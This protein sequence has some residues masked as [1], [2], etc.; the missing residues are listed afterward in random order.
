MVISE[1]AYAFWLKPAFYGR[2]CY[3][4]LAEIEL[5]NIACRACSVVSF[6][7]TKCELEA[8]ESFHTFECK[9]M[10]V[11]Q[12]L[13]SGH[14]ALRMI[15]QVGIER[16]LELYEQNKNRTFNFQDEYSGDYDDVLMLADNSSMYSPERLC[17]IASGV[18]FIVKLAK[19][20]LS[21]T[22]GDKLHAFGGLLLKHVLQINCN[23]IA[24]QFDTTETELRQPTLGS[25]LIVLG[26]AIYPTVALCN[27]TCDRKSLYTIFRNTTIAVKS[28]AGVGVGEEVTLCYG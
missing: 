5:R 14:L 6:C 13:S 20:Q 17:T 27:H 2:F 16:S 11:M 7:S 28:T 23:T 19:A 10:D 25:N 9:L 1:K 21:S 26:M 22:L 3:N 18:A 15:L 12:I 8:H 4:C 24:I